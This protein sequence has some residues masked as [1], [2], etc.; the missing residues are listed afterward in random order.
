MPDPVFPAV[1]ALTLGIVLAVAAFTPFVAVAYRRHGRLTWR[2]SLIW[3][4]FVVYFLAIWTY[5]LLPLPDP[6]ELRCSKAQLTP[7]FFIQDMTNYPL[8]SLRAA[9]TNPVLLQTGLNVALFLPLGF[10][11][12]ALWGKGVVWAGIVGAGWSLFIELTQLTGV[13]GIYPCAYRVFDVDDLMSNTLGAV[14]GALLALLVPRRWVSTERAPR[15]EPA[16]VTIGRRLT[17]MTVDLVAVLVLGVAAALAGSAAEGWETGSALA[18]RLTL[19]V[20]FGVQ[21]ACVLVS[22][23]TIGDLATE[24]T[25]RPSRPWPLTRRLIRFSAGI[26]GYQLL[27]ALPWPALQGVFTLVALIAVFV[28]PRARSLAGAIA[29]Q[30]LVDARDLGEPSPREVSPTPAS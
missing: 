27:A 12:R 15:G 24:L 9:L 26:G 1:V 16:P 13:W 19:W 30:T 28:A 6:D 11:L 21:A 10:F 7:F 17:A 8:D 5:T 18:E 20:P 3:L 14:L 4:A 22:G 25:L 23:R 29:R 2:H